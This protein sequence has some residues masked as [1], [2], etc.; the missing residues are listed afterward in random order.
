MEKIKNSYLVPSLS[1]ENTW[2][3]FTPNTEMT[4]EKRRKTDGSYFLWSSLDL[5]SEIKKELKK[6]ILDKKDVSKELSLSDELMIRHLHKTGVSIV[7]IS[8]SYNVGHSAIQKIVYTDIYKDIKNLKSDF[9][10]QN[11]DIADFLNFTTNTYNADK[12]KKKYE[13]LLVNFYDY[14]KNKKVILRAS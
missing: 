10:L 2:F 8:K 14:I 1:S 5:G 3:L 4:I 6:L 9:N 7:N 12:N 13:E 11:S